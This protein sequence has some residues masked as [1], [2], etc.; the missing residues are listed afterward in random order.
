MF[1]TFDDSPVLATNLSI[2]FS[3]TLKTCSLCRSLIVHLLRDSIE[4]FP[5]VFKFA[6][7]RLE[8]KFNFSKYSL[9]TLLYLLFLILLKCDAVLSL[10]FV[11]AIL[12]CISNLISSLFM[13][14][15]YLIYIALSSLLVISSSMIFDFTWSCG[16]FHL[17]F[18][19]RVWLSFYNL[20]ILSSFLAG[21][22]FE[23]MV[24]SFN[25]L[26]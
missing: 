23:S 25:L 4:C 16:F 21:S 19:I 17:N 12:V 8:L 14:F 2:F 9:M 7:Y 26:A 24:S 13:D 10:S 1:H 15:F 3:G 6:F 20:L 11:L 22:S 18:S 5:W